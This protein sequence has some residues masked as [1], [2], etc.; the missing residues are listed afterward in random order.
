MSSLHL[1]ALWFFLLGTAI[2]SFLNV[3]ILRHEA[4][5]KP[6]GRS[7]CPHCKKQLT[8]RE[9]I[10]IVSYLV[11]KGK[12]TGCGARISLQ[13]PLVELATGI[14]FSLVF[15]HVVDPSTPYNLQPTTLL[16]LMLELAIWSLLVVITVYDL[17]TKLIPDIFSY[18]FAGLSIV[19]LFVTSYAQSIP[20]PYA[21]PPTTWLLAGPLLFLPFYL[22]WKVSDGRWMGLGDGKLA[23]GIGW[24]LGLEH[25]GSAIM[26]SFWLGAGVALTLIAVQHATVFFRSH[27]SNLKP[28]TSNLSLKSE[29]PFG[30]FMVIATCYVYL[31]GFSILPFIW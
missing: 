2:G 1:L 21:L 27:T 24:L 12:C 15:L 8:W 14:L 20:T 13:Y 5:T 31:T 22:L 26:L 25:G 6:T 9:L 10:P 3:I 30:P 16:K 17:R 4:G 28:P 23:L 11:Q 18:S 29:I 19:L 7:A